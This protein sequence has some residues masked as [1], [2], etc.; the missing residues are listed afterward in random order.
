MRRQGY[1]V[2]LWKKDMSGH[3]LLQGE[4]GEDRSSA[5]GFEVSPRPS[6][7]RCPSLPKA[8]CVCVS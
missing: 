1:S 6:A 2:A 7:A 8:F 3:N 4:T 5:R